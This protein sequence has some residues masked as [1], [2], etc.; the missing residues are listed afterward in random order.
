MGP[1]SVTPTVLAAAQAQTGEATTL[2]AVTGCTVKTTGI[3]GVGR[4][5][6]I[7]YSPAGFDPVYATWDLTATSGGSGS[8]LQFSVTV[9]GTPAY[10][11]VNPILVISGVTDSAAP[12]LVKI[13]S[14]TLVS[15]TGYYSS[16]DPVRQQLWLTLVKTFA[17]G[18]ASTVTVTL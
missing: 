5:D 1:K 16:Y 3:A 6:T 11:L 13:G 12:T 2:A 18:T 15:G 8:S 7:T 17:T 9:A 4:T 10:G 14:T